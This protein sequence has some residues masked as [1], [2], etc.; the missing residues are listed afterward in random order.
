M[1]AVRAG[2]H[3]RLASRWGG[4]GCAVI[5]L[6]PWPP[7]APIL[8]VY[9]VRRPSWPASKPRRQGTFGSESRFPSGETAQACT[10]RHQGGTWHHIYARIPRGLRCGPWFGQERTF[11]TWHVDDSGPQRLTTAQARPL[12]R[13]WPRAGLCPPPHIDFGHVWP[14]MTAPV[15]LGPECVARGARTKWRRITYDR[16]IQWRE[17][18]TLPRAGNTR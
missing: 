3:E 11:G 1:A 16:V 4:Q 8:R 17:I 13:T 7:A 2:C 10:A 18:G 5:E 9:C 12:Q 15:A 14:R 6:K